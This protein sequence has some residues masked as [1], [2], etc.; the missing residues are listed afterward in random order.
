[1][2]HSVRQI[3]SKQTCSLAHAYILSAAKWLF[4]LLPQARISVRKSARVQ[5]MRLN[6]GLLLAQCNLRKCRLGLRR[7]RGVE[8][9]PRNEAANPG[10]LL[11][12]SAA[13]SRP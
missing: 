11:R 9:D 2:A 10:I 4:R 1:M 5:T 7:V 6:G 3:S 8:I 13:K 12:F